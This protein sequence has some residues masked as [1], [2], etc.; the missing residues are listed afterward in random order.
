VQA[1]VLARCAEAE[2][3]AETIRAAAVLGTRVDVDVLAQVRRADP[4]TVI[5]DLER[6]LALGLLAE[7]NGAYVFRHEVAREALEASLG[8][9]LRALF[10]R[11]AARVLTLQAGADPMLVAY[12]ARL[13]GARAIASAA[14]TAASRVAADRFDDATAPHPPG[15]APGPAGCGTPPRWACSREPRS[16]W[17]VIPARPGRDRGSGQ[18]GHSRRD[19]SRARPR[20]APASVPAAR[21]VAPVPRGRAMRTRHRAA[22]RDGR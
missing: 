3:A 12:H 15:E 7:R 6:G 9:P 13:S 21:A 19:R 2:G 20:P 11:E 8:S 5:A 22:G 10:H 17:T 4:V 1:A 16:S 14:L 18:R